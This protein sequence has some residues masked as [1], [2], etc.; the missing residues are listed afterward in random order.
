MEGIC[1]V[2]ERGEQEIIEQ[3]VAAIWRDKKETWKVSLLLIGFAVLLLAAT[4]VLLPMSSELEEIRGYSVRPAWESVEGKIMN[5]LFDVKFIPGEVDPE[6][7]LSVEDP[8]MLV[9]AM[10]MT[11]HTE[12]TKRMDAADYDYSALDFT[13]IKMNNHSMSIINPDL[14]KTEMYRE[15]AE[16]AK[17]LFEAEM[18]RREAAAR[19]LIRARWAAMG[20]IIAIYIGIAYLVVTTCKKNGEK[21]LEQVRSGQF[22]ATPAV[23]TG[24]DQYRSRYSSRTSIEVTTEDG[25]ELKIKVGGLQ[26]DRFRSGGKCYVIRYPD[27]DPEVDPSDLVWAGLTAPLTMHSPE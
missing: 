14:E 3:G 11:G 12:I 16:K 27:Q 2:P 26:Y 6:T 19:P 1:Q 15:E 22:S 23:M 4:I 8:G 7:A 9:F 24:R 21:R 20:L 17:A 13:G 10:A 5:R 25:R 18:D